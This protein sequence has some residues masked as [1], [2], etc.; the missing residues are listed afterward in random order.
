MNSITEIYRKFYSNLKDL[1]GQYENAEAE[2]HSDSE[3]EIEDIQRQIGDMEEKLKKIDEYVLRIQGFRSLAEKHLISRN[4]FAIHPVKPNFNH[5]KNWSMMMD[6]QSTGD[7]PYAQRV[8]VASRCYECYLEEAGKEFNEKIES[9]RKEMETGKKQ[10]AEALE[11]KLKSL[12]EQMRILATGEGMA[13]F[14]AEAV[15]A[16]QKYWY[17]KAPAEYVSPEKPKD[18]LSPGA[19]S[20]PMN[21]PEEQRVQIGNLF[22]RFYDEKAG[23]VLLPFEIAADHEFAVTVNCTPAKTRQLNR[24]LQNFILQVIGNNPAGSEKIYVIDAVRFNSSVL[25]SLRQL[26]GSFALE[27]MPRNEE[28]LTDTLDQIVS[29]FADLEDALGFSDSVTEYN[30][31]AEEKKKLPRMLLILIGWPDSF[32]HDNAEMIRRIMTNY[33]RYGISFI[34]V[35]YHEENADREK[36]KYLPE[37]AAQ[38]AIK[39]RMLPGETTVT[40][41]N[42]TPQYFVWYTLNEDL[43]ESY[44]TTLGKSRK[45]V[46]TLGTEYVKRVTL[47]GFSRYTREY[48]NIELPYAVDSKDAVHDLTFE[49]E[50]FATFIMGASRSGKSTL[51]HTLIT[52]IINTYHPDNVELWLVDF[53]MSEFAQYMEH[54]P[55][56]I[57]YILLDESPELVYDIIDRL[58][59]E[60]KRRQALFARNGWQKITDVPQGQV[61]MPVIFVIMDEFSIMSQA[62]RASRESTYLPDYCLLLQNLLAKGAALGFK[63]LFSSQTFTQGV[64]GLTDTAKAQIQQRVAMKAARDEITA[65]LELSSVLKTDRVVNWIDT[66]PV[67]YVLVKHRISEDKMDVERLKVMYF[68]N[69]DFSPRDH[70]IDSLCK[71]TARQEFSAGDINSYLDKNPVL[72][73]GRTYESFARKK[74]EFLQYRNLPE[75]KTNL[76]GEEIFLNIGTP[77]RMRSI[78]PVTLMPEAREN[79]LIFG[80]TVEEECAGSVISSSL[81]SM[82]LEGK[83][84]EI[85]SYAKSHIYRANRKVWEAY[86]RK[87]GIA[88]VCDRIREL[89]K[90]VHEKKEDSRLIVILG[91]DRLWTDFE[92]TEEENA[93][94]P[95]VL[96]GRSF[97][98]SGAAKRK[99]LSSMAELA[100]SGAFLDEHSENEKEEA[101]RQEAFRQLG[102]A[103]QAVRTEAAQ[104]V[105]AAEYVPAETQPEKD[106]EQTAAADVPYNAQE[107]LEYIIRQGSR[108]GYHF[109]VYM[110]SLA[111]LNQTG[112]RTE[113]F[114]H[115]MAFHVSGADSRDLFGN[116]NASTLPDHIFLYT[117]TLQQLSFRPYLNP[118]FSWENWSVGEDGVI[119]KGY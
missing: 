108:L 56:H 54:K 34:A 102:Q 22:G 71:M 25:G 114:K 76:T 32:S 27:H 63:F 55:P 37:F 85:W 72:V 44:A 84:T 97:P 73:D 42:G 95:T 60:M 107:D 46:E 100:A 43:P 16:N 18:S 28:Q 98:V 50:N 115:R 3:K 9:L 111:D 29:S 51:L 70:L 7:D 88:A 81:Q 57:K 49:N 4:I 117:D 91:L 61:Y 106:T 87:E 65:T 1:C 23:R 96:P 12:K 68:K 30:L 24:G 26:E 33:E 99:K 15:K 110:N 11:A 40:E 14:S 10:D 90:L 2:L 19:C 64:S 94:P 38:N 58:T 104:K 92:Y 119:S 75:I 101:L 78:Q 67:H 21:F 31:S 6:P 39:I 80:R 109:L 45:K 8:Y 53:K 47:D 79:I 62:I 13:E 86:D 5:L 112:L 36:E 82:T 69:N 66:L 17:E 93:A 74:E 52:G 48:R 77:R 89:K 118:E 41:G 105:P 113:M 83:K 20:Y 103:E 59:E 35:S 116:T